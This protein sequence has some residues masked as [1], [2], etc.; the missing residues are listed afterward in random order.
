MYVSI[1]FEIKLPNKKMTYQVYVFLFD[2]LD[3]ITTTL[4]ISSLEISS[5]D[6]FP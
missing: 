4:E 1:K 2:M 3:L 6:T 5:L